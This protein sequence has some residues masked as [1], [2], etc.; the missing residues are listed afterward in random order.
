MN[1]VVLDTRNDFLSSLFDQNDFSKGEGII[2]AVSGGSDSL[3]MLFLL[4]E[5]LA[6]FGRKERLVAVTVDHGLRHES[7]NEARIVAELCAKNNITHEIFTLTWYKKKPVRAISQRSRVARYN[8]L[9][10]AAEKYDAR[11]IVTGH[12]LNDQAETYTMRLLRGGTSWRGLA[13]MPR[14]SL[15]RQKFLLLR[16]LLGIWRATLRDYLL[17]HSI[18]WI[19]D[20]TNANPSYER[21]RIRRS[22]NDKAVLEA[23][24]AVAAA[25]CKRQREAEIIAVLTLKS[26]MRLQSERLWFDLQPLGVDEE[27]AFA[28]LIALSAAIMGGTQHLIANQQ[29]KLKTFLTA[30]RNRLRRTT[31]SGAVIEITN[32][33]LRIW[34]EKRNLTSC[35]LVPGQTTIW[36]GR[37][38]VNNSGWETVLLRPPTQ[39][40]VRQILSELPEY[41]AD[42]HELHFPSLETSCMVCGKSGFDLPVLTQHSLKN[43]NIGLQRITLP[44]DWLIS[45][46]DIPILEALLPIFAIKAGKMTKTTRNFPDLE[47]LTLATIKSKSMLQG[48]MSLTFP[49]FDQMELI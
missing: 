4:Y 25:A 32:K 24:K 14:L 20:P 17:K 42:V 23:Q 9:C 47:A 7:A 3:A 26:R 6:R 31:I 28:T 27:K 22:L 18:A 1:A 21:V 5:Y 29:L 39:E 45:E 12:T 11:V 37:Y 43:S 35:L 48:N 36:D 46:Y 38:R 44:F 10:D 49:S 34:R 19:D 8:L 33:F 41:L 40:E 13:A 15:L 30:G 16:P 2:A